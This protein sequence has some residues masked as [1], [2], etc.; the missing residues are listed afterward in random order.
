MNNIRFHL[1]VNWTATYWIFY[2]CLCDMVIRINEIKQNLL[3]HYFMDLSRQKLVSTRTQE[4]AIFIHMTHWVH[5]ITPFL[6]VVLKGLYNCRLA[7]SLITHIPTCF[8][9][10]SSKHFIMQVKTVVG[11]Q[12]HK[13][14][15]VFY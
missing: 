3:N 8:N 12:V 15:P 5:V 2:L 4:A 6:P 13:F 11:I 7:A 10:L 14:T 1:L 9:Y